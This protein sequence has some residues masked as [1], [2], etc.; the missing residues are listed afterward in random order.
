[1]LRLPVGIGV[2]LAAG[3]LAACGGGDDD[4]ST[5]SPAASATPSPAATETATTTSS[6]TTSTATATAASPTPVTTPPP[7][8]VP[9]VQVYS[10]PAGSRPH[11]VAPAPDGSVWYTGQGNGTLG[12][13]DPTTGQVEE[14]SLGPGSAPHGVIVGPDGAAWVTDGGQNAIVRVDAETHAVDVFELPA[15]RPNANLNTAAFDGRGRLW[16]TG[17]NGIYGV[18][19]PATEAMTVYDAP[20][21]RGPYGITGTPSGDVYYASLAGSHIASIDLDTGA[22]TPIDPPTAGQGA[23]RVWSDS[24]GRIWGSEWNA[25]QVGV[26]DPADSSWQE[27][28]LPG[29]NP[30][31]YSVYVDERDVVWLTDFG[32]NA[33][34]SFEPASE[35]FT[36][37]PLEPANANVRQML[38][39]P[40]EVWGAQSGADS[41]IVIRQGGTIAVY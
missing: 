14:V 34:V 8:P 4:A 9:S 24:R 35:V 26:Y 29:S 31:T 21:G 20:R 7:A 39:R 22:A 41:L 6:Q 32:A 37:Y 36:Q 15:D 1:V 18:F 38:G 2:L 11:D 25:G 12:R 33:I 40:G 5:E 27:W 30:Q 16:F 23:R 3:A 17:Q 19:D 28:R 10:V 13:L